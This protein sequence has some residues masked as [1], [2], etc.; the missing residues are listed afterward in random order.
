LIVWA[1]QHVNVF[2]DIPKPKKEPDG[3]DPSSGIGLDTIF[4][5]SS[6]LW[7]VAHGDIISSRAMAHIFENV[8]KRE[9]Q[10]IFE[11]IWDVIG[12]RGPF[13]SAVWSQIGNKALQYSKKDS[14]QSEYFHP[15]Q[16]CLGMSLEDSKSKPNVDKFK[17]ARKNYLQTFKNHNP[18]VKHHTYFQVALHVICLSRH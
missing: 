10:K 4:D 17:S 1:N 11:Y 3:P 6:E 2:A 9:D 16:L 7:N 15:S 13:S 5:T 12:R 18:L 8:D 14:V